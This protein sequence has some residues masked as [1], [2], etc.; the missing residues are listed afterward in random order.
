M[1]EETEGVI[2]DVVLSGGSLGSV[3]RVVTLSRVEEWGSAHMRLMTTGSIRICV[4]GQWR[5]RA[6]A[7]AEYFVLMLGGIWERLELVQYFHSSI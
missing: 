2:R 7:I 4:L 1:I 6:L 3:R 5:C